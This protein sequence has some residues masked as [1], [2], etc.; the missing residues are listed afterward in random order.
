MPAVLRPAGVAVLLLAPLGAGAPPA[1]AQDCVAP[2]S[3]RAVPEGAGVRLRWDGLLPPDATWSLRRGHLAA[4]RAGMRDDI[5]VL[6]GLVVPTASDDADPGETVHFVVACG[7]PSRSCN[8][9]P[10]LC[11]RAYDEVAYATTHNAMSSA[12]DG[13]LLPN[14]TFAVPRQLADGVR[15]LMLDVHRWFGEPHLC[16]G[17]CLGGSRRLEDG[18]LEIRAFLETHPREVVTLIFESYV[19]VEE[20]EG[21]FQ[22]SG[23]LA[24]AHEQSPGDAW[25]TLGEMI[26]AGRRLVV[27]TDRDGG[28]RPWYHDVWAF[29]WETPFAAETPDDFTCEAN[30]GTPGNDLFILNHFLTNPTALPSLAEQVNHD[31]ELTARVLACEARWSHLPNFVTVD[32]HDIGDVLGAVETLNAR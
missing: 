19:T 3:L 4:L 8:G 12:E 27:F 23:L 13:W 11:D 7:T 1:A 21:A 30:R 32:F 14:Q 16:H 2:T 9:G 22:A 25:P 10:Q 5:V 17:T 6:D 24:H 29:A 26:D 28:L 18:L 20:M 15:A 31:P